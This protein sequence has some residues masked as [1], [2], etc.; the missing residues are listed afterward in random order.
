MMRFLVSRFRFGP[1]IAVI[2]VMSTARSSI[3]GVLPHERLIYTT[4]RPANKELYL[5]EPGAPAPKPITNDPA[6]DY[7]AT[8]SPDGR[9][10]VFCSERAGNP[11]LYAQDLTRSH[12]SQPL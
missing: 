2:A 8:F 10:L 11:N 1:C 12:A 4:L 5:F 9:W 6:L 3:A 7:D